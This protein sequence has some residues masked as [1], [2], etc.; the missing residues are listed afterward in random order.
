MYNQPKE[1]SSLSE[2]PKYNNRSIDMTSDLD[3]SQDVLEGDDLGSFEVYQRIALN[4]GDMFDAWDLVEVE[5]YVYNIKRHGRVIHRQVHVIGRDPT[6]GQRY[7][8][9]LM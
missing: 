6:N 2:L 5:S 8:A 1:V 4:I 7:S 3:F 9:Y